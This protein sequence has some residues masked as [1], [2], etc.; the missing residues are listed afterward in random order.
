MSGTAEDTGLPD[1]SVDLITVAQALHWFDLERARAEFARVLRPGG[2]CAVI[3]NNRHESGDAFHDAYERFLLEF[4]IDYSSVKSQHMGRKRLAQ[5]FT[6]AQMKYAVFPNSQ[7]L[8]WE[9]FEGRVLSSSFIPRPE[10]ERFRRMQ[11]ELR[12]LFERHQSGGV[13]TVEYDFVVCYG[14]IVKKASQRL[15]GSAG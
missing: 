4:G 9:G 15:N 10:H 1:R 7:A 8:T 3:Y 14:Q 11:S 2:W 6:P 13:V 12:H 5:F